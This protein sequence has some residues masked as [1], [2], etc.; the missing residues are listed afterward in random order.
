M[1]ARGFPFFS[2]FVDGER[3][4]NKIDFNMTDVL[5]SKFEKN[6]E[7]TLR[8][9]YVDSLVQGDKLIY[10]TGH[11]ASGKS[12]TADRL[13]KYLLFAGIDSV[14]ILYDEDPLKRKASV[15]ILDCQRLPLELPSNTAGH[16]H[17]VSDNDLT[18]HDVHSNV[19]T[20][21]IHTSLQYDWMDEVY[22]FVEEL[23]E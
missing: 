19:P 20:L 18:P 12:W 3:E 5:Q 4:K 10:I 21:Y 1:G 9:Q 11:A 13:R 6:D 2:L 23:L 16:I 14:N 7:V 17:L 8:Q 15:V 22:T